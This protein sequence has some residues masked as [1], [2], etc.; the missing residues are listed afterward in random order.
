MGQ[1]NE[2]VILKDGSSIHGEVLTS[3]FKLKLKWGELK[4]RKQ[5]ILS[6]EYRNPPHVMEDEVQ[7]SAGTRLRG[8]LQPEV[9][10]VR[11][12]ETSQVLSIPKEDILAIVLFT[13]RRG[14]VS[15]ATRRALSA[16][17]P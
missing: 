2:L 12:E 5:D 1:I 4:L 13:G 14:R 16:L 17:R 6:I 3:L 8:D 10:R 7:V 11:F 15:V 9:I